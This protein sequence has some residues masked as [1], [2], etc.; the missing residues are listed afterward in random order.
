MHTQEE[1]ESSKIRLAEQ[2]K[3]LYKNKDFKEIILDGY[4]EQG[5]VY[6]TKNYTR[7]K[8]EHKANL[9][10]Q[11]NSRSDLWKYLDS[12][13]GEAASIIEARDIE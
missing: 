1:L 12:I 7:V 10:E 3:K 11:L 5:S 4:L 6:L 2:L 9:V 13:E 8:E